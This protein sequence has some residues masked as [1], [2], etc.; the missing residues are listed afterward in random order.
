MLILFVEGTLLHIRSSHDLPLYSQLKTS[1]FKPELLCNGAFVAL[2]FTYYW[3]FYWA[4]PKKSEHM[5][6]LVTLWQLNRTWTSRFVKPSPCP[7][8][9]SSSLKGPDSS[10]W[11]LCWLQVRT[12]FFKNPHNTNNTYHLLHLLHRKASLFVQGASHVSA[13]FL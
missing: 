6:S 1:F 13:H 12:D 7:R 10:G 11:L 9:T 2:L 3:K 8:C 5:T 4:F